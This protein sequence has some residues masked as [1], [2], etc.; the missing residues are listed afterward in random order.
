MTD[1][2]DEKRTPPV[3]PSDRIPIP[4]EHSEFDRCVVER[5]SQDVDCPVCGG[6]VE[7]LR[8]QTGQAHILVWEGFDEDKYRT[9]T[10]HPVEEMLNKCRRCGWRVYM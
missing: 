5:E 4:R 8:R 10:T 7:Y 3:P 2:V 6:Q 1:A 9:R